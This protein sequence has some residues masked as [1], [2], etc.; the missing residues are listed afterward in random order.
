MKL[1]FSSEQFIVVVLFLFSSDAKRKEERKKKRSNTRTVNFAGRCFLSDRLISCD[2][3]C[4]SNNGWNFTDETRKK[5]ETFSGRC[6]DSKKR[7]S[8]FD[9]FTVVGCSTPCRLSPESISST[10][11]CCIEWAKFL[12]ENCVVHYLFGENFSKER[13]LNNFSREKSC[14]MFAQGIHSFRLRN[15]SWADRKRVIE[16]HARSRCLSCDRLRT[17]WNLFFWCDDFV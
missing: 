17:N 16:F 1:S 7:F 14:E 15:G 5:M 6:V 12:Q 9:Y 2:L 3:H 10:Q 8:R 11:A 4:E 13:K